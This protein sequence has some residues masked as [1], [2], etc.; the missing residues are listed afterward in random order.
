[1]KQTRKFMRVKKVT[2]GPIAAGTSKTEPTVY[3]IDSINPALAYFTIQFNS[4]VEP[5]L[6]TVLGSLNPDGP[7]SNIMTGGL[8]TSNN[9]VNVPQCPYLKFICDN[10]SGIS[11]ATVDIFIGS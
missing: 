7:F 1:M 11:E 5:V 4:P 6:F 9:I 8:A 2:I 3:E 10:T